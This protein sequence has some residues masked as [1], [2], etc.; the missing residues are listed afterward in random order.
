MN[1][2]NGIKVDI[3][4]LKSIVVNYPSDVLITEWRRKK[5]VQQKSLGRGYSEFE[6]SKPEKIDLDTIS[7]VRIDKEDGPEIDEAEAVYVLGLLTECEASDRP[8]RDGNRYRVAL[9]VMRG[10]DTVHVLRVPTMKQIMDYERQRSSV[11]TGPYG[12]QEIR[13]NYRAAADLY[14]AIVDKAET[15]GYVGGIVPIV[16]KAEAVN[17]LLQEIRSAHEEVADS[18]E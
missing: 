7:A 1:D 5:K 3:L 13:I 12:Q 10:I 9:K 14:D 2:P 18:G 16:H 15:T 6:S 4:G 17:T 8:E 11:R